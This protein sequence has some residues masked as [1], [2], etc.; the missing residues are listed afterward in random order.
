MSTVAASRPAVDQATRRRVGKA[1]LL[2]AGSWVAYLV[3]AFTVSA[4]YEEA[5]VDASEAT[6]TP[7]NR[8]PAETLAEITADHPWS[9]LSALVLVFVPVLLILAVRRARAV[10]GERWGVRLAW[11][12]AAVWWFYFLLNAGLAAGPESLPPLTR[13][14]DVLTVPLVSAGSVL[15]VAAFVLSAL[16]LRRAGWRPWATAIAAGVALVLAAVSVVTLV[17]SGFDEPVPP[18]A[19][20][21]AELIVGIALLVGSRR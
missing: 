18:I 4:G 19:L 17:T 16:G 1:F 12:G 21:P 13:D 8:L 15:A 7:V 20:L 10:T 2:A 3:L 5:L 14:L 6:D 9:N 11:L